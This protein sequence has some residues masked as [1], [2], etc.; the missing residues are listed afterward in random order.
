MKRFFVLLLAI[1]VSLSAL[2]SCNSGQEQKESEVTQESGTGSVATETLA[3]DGGNLGNIDYSKI[4]KSTLYSRNGKKIWFGSYPQ[5]E[6]TDAS[7]KAALNSMA[8]ALPTSVNSQAWTSYGYYVDGAVSDFMWYIDVEWGSQ[9]YRGV[10]FNAYRPCSHLNSSA[11]DNSCQDDNSYTV[12]NIYWFLY[13]PISWTVLSENTA[14][15]TAVVIC[16]MIIDSQAFDAD[17]SRSNNYAQSTIRKW[18]N[19]TFYNTAFTQL[20]KGLILTTVLDNS[21]ASTGYSSNG[22]VCENTSDKVFLLSYAE[23]VNA[24]HGF[25]SDDMAYD[26]LRQKKPTAYA[27]SQGLD[28]DTKNY[29]GNGW[30]Q[31]RS[32]YYSN[33]AIARTVH[34]SGYI[35]TSFFVYAT[36]GGI[37]PAL[38]MKL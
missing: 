1:F 14:N 3:S 38:Q 36:D 33:S 4:D 23:V 17:G 5:T 10:Y 18:L 26:T 12:G 28:I 27:K 19:E 32:P 15:A 13:E 6:V 35:S 21:V 37:V 20:Q 25:T 8:G 22:Y 11:P 7:A 30:W 29:N 34:F 2:V 24:N 16:D 31:L 9:K